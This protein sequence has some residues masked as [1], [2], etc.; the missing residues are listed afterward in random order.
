MTE[1][2]REKIP[3]ILKVT[4]LAHYR[5]RLEL[6]SGSILELNMENRLHT[7]RFC[8]LAESKVFF[9]VTTDGESLYF[10]KAL[11]ITLREAMDLAMIPPPRYQLRED[12]KSS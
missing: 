5:L 3:P 10:G 11:E 2:N 8:P 9:T 7:I 1:Y 12:E 4:P 6:G